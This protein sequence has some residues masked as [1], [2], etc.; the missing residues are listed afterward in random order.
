MSL[1]DAIEHA[2]ALIQG[3][4]DD[5]STHAN[6]NIP[7]NLHYGEDD[8]KRAVNIKKANLRATLGNQPSLRQ[9]L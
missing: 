4:A 1:P 6:H 7:P 8:V 9:E 5:G 3:S 2:S